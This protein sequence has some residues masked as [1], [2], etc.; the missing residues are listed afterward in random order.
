VNDDNHEYNKDFQ[1]IPL[2][3]NEP[4]NK[5]IQLKSKKS[6]LIFVV[7]FA[8]IGLSLVAITYAARPDSAPT[9]VRG[10]RGEVAIDVLGRRLPDVAKKYNIATEELEELF[11]SDNTLEIDGDDNLL[12]VDPIEEEEEI[13]Y[14]NAV[15]ELALTQI[16]NETDEGIVASAVTFSAAE[17]L[18]LNSQPNSPLTIYLDFDGHT[19]VGTSWNSLTGET[20]MVS[21]PYDTDGNPSAFNETERRMIF[22]VWQSVSEDFA[23][24]NVNVTT[25]EPG[26]E[27]LRKSSSTDTEFGI[28]AI[29]TPTNWRGSGGV[30]YVGSFSWSSDTPVYIFN[31]SSGLRMAD[32]VSHEVGH[33]VGLSHDGTTA[34]VTYYGGHGDW[35]PLLG[36]G[37][38]QLSQFSKGEYANA[39]N[40]Q[41]DL[42]IMTRHMPYLV[43]DTGDILGQA[44]PLGQVNGAY[45]QTGLIGRT[46]DV[47]VYSFNW[48]G[49]ALTMSVGS[50]VKS[51]TSTRLIQN[52]DPFFRIL[53]A[54]GKQVAFSDPAGPVAASVNIDLPAGSYFAEVKGTGYLDPLSTGYSNYASLGRYIITGSSSTA[55]PPPPSNEPPTAQLTATPTSGEAPLTVAFSSAGST[56]PEG[57]ALTYLW[58][59]GNGTTSTLANPSASYS[60]PG[61]YTITL[62]VTDDV[63]QKASAS[64]LVTVQAAVQIMS[65]QSVVAEKVITGKQTYANV[66]VKIVNA[67]GQP[68]SGATVT[69]SWTGATTGTSSAIT[70]SD[71]TVLIRSKNLKFG[72]NTSRTLTF[73]VTSVTHSSTILNYQWDNA[74]KSVSVT[75]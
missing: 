58:N 59:L 1:S 64:T 72:R 12:Y 28:R 4:K 63:G 45:Y 41:D 2:E 60:N 20:E 49:G 27:K 25:K 74:Q 34:D 42:N 36:S 10:A 26:V 8:F 62:T 54:N 48:S 32:T 31:V 71:G 68:V 21:A 14:E 43:D 24:Y 47:D 67:S 11:L 75:F 66:T 17:A 53:D 30:A 56:D 46:G 6:L 70:G 51:V 55:T 15:E 73:T 65:I 37:S 3:P 22:D 57:K 39:N 69:G 18:N 38:R 61:T 40:T 52:L 13:E 7:A 50:G 29:I 44:K 35:R 33:A 19:T 5:K 23:P 9:V 16:V